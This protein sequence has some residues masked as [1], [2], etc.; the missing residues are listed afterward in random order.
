MLPILSNITK[1]VLI[2]EAL[3]SFESVGLDKKKY[4]DLKR[5]VA[6]YCKTEGSGNSFSTDYILE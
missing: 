6:D 3:F 2:S 1:L 5:T 4:I